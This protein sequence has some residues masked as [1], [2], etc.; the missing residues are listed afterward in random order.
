M[1][2]NNILSAQSQAPSTVT[3]KE[4]IASLFNPY[5][6]TQSDDPFIIHASIN[7]GKCGSFPTHTHGLADKGMPEFIMDPL[8]F[9]PEGNSDIINTAYVFFRN[10]KMPLN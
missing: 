2:Y 7:C 8:A 1:L 10:G 4:A 5:R 6:P 3:S 9:G